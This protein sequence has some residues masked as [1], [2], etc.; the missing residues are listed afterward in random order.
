MD[1]TGEGREE[2]NYDARRR[3]QRVERPRFAGPG[4]ALPLHAEISFGGN[5]AENEWMIGNTRGN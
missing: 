2:D 3:Q 4:F 5:P 1:F